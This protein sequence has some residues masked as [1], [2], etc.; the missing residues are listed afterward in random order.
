MK[1]ELEITL[2]RKTQKIIIDNK[3]VVVLIRS[4]GGKATIGIAAPQKMVVDRLE[5]RERTEATPR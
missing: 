4:R 5:Y 2:K 3:I 1:Q